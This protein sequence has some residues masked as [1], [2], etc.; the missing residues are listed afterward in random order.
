MNPTGKR[1]YLVTEESSR[2]QSRVLESMA[3]GVS[4]AN[5]DGVIVYANPAEDA[6]FGCEPGELIGRHFTLLSIYPAEENARMVNQVTEQLKMQEAW[7]GEFS[8]RRKDGTPFTTFARITT[9][10]IAEKR[11]WVCAREDITERQRAEE[12]RIQLLALE[13]TAHAE[14]ER[15]ARLQAEAAIRAKDELLAMV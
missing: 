10:G 11:F 13:R 8:H 5:E 3:V 7:S 4:L 6:M 14:A 12:D 2:L 1:Q 15:K 9:L